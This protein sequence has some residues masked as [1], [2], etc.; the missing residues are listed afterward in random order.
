MRDCFLG[1][2]ITVG[3]V[4]AAAAIPV[5]S[6]PAAAQAL[7]VSAAASAPVPKTPWGES[8]LQGIWTE[9][10]DTPFQ[11]PAKYANQEY[12][13]EAQRAELDLA[14]SE[15]LGKRANDREYA[16]AYN[17]AAF[18]TIK[19]TGPRTSLI[20]DPP[21]GR[22]PPLTEAARKTAAADR[23]Y[24]LALLRA[25]ETCKA[26]LAQCRGG[27]YDSVPSPRRAEP[28]PRY[29]AANRSRQCAA[30][31]RQRL[32]RDCPTWWRRDYAIA[33]AVSGPCARR[34]VRYPRTCRQSCKGR[35][36]SR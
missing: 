19:R 24:R 36:M 32:R 12:F 1:A 7:S 14:R 25:T 23:D 4:V 13:T 5:S 10:F 9:E 28:P 33:S 17:L 11:R 30:D 16:G 22:I 15:L 6:E 2:T 3:V 20:V 29:L 18:T 34:C 8:D 31:R 26:N 35:P 21:D 27:T